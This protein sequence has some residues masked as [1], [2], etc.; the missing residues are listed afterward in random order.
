MTMIM[1]VILTTASRRLRSEVP[2][3]IFGPERT[4]LE[5][6]CGSQIVMLFFTLKGLLSRAQSLVE[7]EKNDGGSRFSASLVN[8]RNK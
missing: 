8:V 5:L 7:F 4:Q 6:S 1:I 3:A 2:S